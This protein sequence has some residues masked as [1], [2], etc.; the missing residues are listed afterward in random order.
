MMGDSTCM[1]NLSVYDTRGKTCD[2]YHDN[3][4]LCGF[5]DSFGPMCEKYETDPR[6]CVG[7]FTASENCCACGGQ[8]KRYF[9]CN[10]VDWDDKQSSCDLFEGREI[11]HRD[12]EYSYQSMTYVLNYEDGIL[13]N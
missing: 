7:N 10:Y 9:C 11:T 3:P 12:S 5:Y 1:D 13:I 4:E 8:S 2:S 6:G